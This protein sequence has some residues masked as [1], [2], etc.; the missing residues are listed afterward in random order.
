MQDTTNNAFSSYECMDVMNEDVAQYKKDPTLLLLACLLV[1]VSI[2]PKTKKKNEP[3]YLW[4][5]TLLSEHM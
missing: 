1:F 2:L 5:F 4:F 3:L